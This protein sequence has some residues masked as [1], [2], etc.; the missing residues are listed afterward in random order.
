M[1]AFHKRLQNRTLKKRLINQIC[2]IFGQ[3]MTGQLGKSQATGP[4]LYVD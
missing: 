4:S 1:P 2:R 3:S